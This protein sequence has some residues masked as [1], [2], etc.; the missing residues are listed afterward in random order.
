MADNLLCTL[1]LASEKASRIARLCRENQDL[2]SLLIQEKG[3]KFN[4]IDFKTLADVFIQQTVTKEVKTKFGNLADYVQGEENNQFTNTLGETVSVEIGSEVK[5]TSDML[6]KVLAGNDAAARVL[7]EAAHEE[8]SLE[9][10][11]LVEPDV[12]KDIASS[13]LDLENIGIW[14]DPI[15]CTS[16]YVKGI[17]DM[18]PTA[19]GIYEAGLQ[20]VMV[21]IG[22]YSLDD[23]KPILGVVN[24]PFCQRNVNNGQK[25]WKSRCIWGFSYNNINRNNLKKNNTI[26]NEKHV[27]V[28]S[29]HDPEAMSVMKPLSSTIDT[30]LSR[31]A[32]HKCVTVVD[33]LAE[34]FVYTF[35]GSY[36]WD[37][38]A[39]HAILRSCEGG[40]A[41]LNEA[42][43]KYDTTESEND[44]LSV[45]DSCQVKYNEASESN[46]NHNW[47]ANSGGLLVYNGTCRSN[48]A[49]R[50]ILKAFASTRS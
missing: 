34:L 1:I 27:V 44:F 15:D 4:E 48:D 16:Q 40:I 11:S 31:G 32:G 47:K 19:H 46:K 24:Q 13:N 33:K 3:E 17:E 20:C 29:S 9:I 30:C 5:E 25:K 41:V 10:E 36:K 14:I 45:L 50:Q 38:C 18:V 21:L 49:M 7:A 2:F 37:T 35:D 23:G 28:L 39:P 6:S 43:E 26:H 42:I 12:L 22:V 8:I